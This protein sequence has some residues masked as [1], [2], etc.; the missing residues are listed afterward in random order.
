MTTENANNPKENS[1]PVG[2]DIH[3]NVTASL[4]QK[5]LTSDDFYRLGNKFRREG[6]WHEA[7][8]NYI[9]AIEK[10]PDSPA[11]EARKM[12]EDILGYYNKDMYN[13]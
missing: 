2:Y 6:K 12:L 8:N 4:P 3:D 10:D 11:V 7:I 1:E 5:P 13:P 9:A